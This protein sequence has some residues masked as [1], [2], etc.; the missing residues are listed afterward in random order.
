MDLVLTDHAS[1]GPASM[2][3]G[4]NHHHG[5]DGQRSA[6][7]ASTPQVRPA[8]PTE[9]PSDATTGGNSSQIQE[10]PNSEIQRLPRNPKATKAAGRVSRPM[11]SKTPREISV[12]A[13]RGATIAAWLA[14]NPMTAFQAAGA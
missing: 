1:T 14:I 5:E 6:S 8:C 12:I 2:D 11:I 3:R 13:C 10:V 7:Q 4:S 9:S